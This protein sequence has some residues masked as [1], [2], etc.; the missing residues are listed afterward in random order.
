MS[1][2]TNSRDM[3]ERQFFYKSKMKNEKQINR[4]GFRASIPPFSF[5]VCLA[6]TRRPLYVVLKKRSYTEFCPVFCSG[7]MLSDAVFESGFLTKN[8]ASN[9]GS[10]VKKIRQSII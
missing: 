5:P 10:F 4:F 8:P 6:K 7:E 2:K 9:S 1:R 3:G